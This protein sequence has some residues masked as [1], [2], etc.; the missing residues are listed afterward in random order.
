MDVLDFIDSKDIREFNRYYSF[1][2]SE[3]AIIC[4]MNNQRS[5]QE[6]MDFLKEL[7]VN[8]IDFDTVRYDDNFQAFG[9]PERNLRVIIHDTVKYWNNHKPDE[10]NDSSVVYIAGAY[11]LNNQHG[12][13]YGVFYSFQDAIGVLGNNRL[14]W[15]NS[16][17]MCA[18][19]SREVISRPNESITYTLGKDLQILK[20]SKPAEDSIVTLQYSYSVHI[21]VPFKRGDILVAESERVR[22]ENSFYRGTTEGSS[23]VCLINQFSRRKGLF[24]ILVIVI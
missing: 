2:P 15:D 7:E 3:Q 17:D 20:V 19:V 22:P 10:N 9:E 24:R 1:T 23:I 13:I 16:Q 6:K 5:Y 14:H 18:Y 11:P 21:P 4:M 8:N 12:T